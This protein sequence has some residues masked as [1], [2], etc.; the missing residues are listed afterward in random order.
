MADYFGAAESLLGGIGSFFGGMTAAS[1][2]K[3]AAQYYSK[4]A[5]LT[6]VET[7]LKQ[8]ALNRQLYQTQGAG[9]AIA[10]AGGVTA[11]GSVEDI[12]RSNA[13]QGALSKAIVNLQ[14]AIDVGSYQAKAQEAIAQAQAQQ[15]GGIG[16]LLGGVLGA[17][18]SL[19][20][21]DRLKTGLELIFRREDG[22]GFY[23]Y[24]VI[25]APGEFEGVLASEVEELMP[26]A[27]TYD[28]AGYR[29]VDYDRVGLPFR[30][31]A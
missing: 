27:I 3:K 5:Q 8:V 9:Q 28:A 12:M 25:G 29:Q 7:G 22:I 19:F 30:A 2:S 17:V 4:A 14:G 16:G 18:G 21:D 15:G 1:G 13:Q 10:A 23:R 20:S 24:S 26:D 31:A 11:G 6:Q